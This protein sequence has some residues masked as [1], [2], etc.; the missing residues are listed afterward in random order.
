MTFPS[1]LFLLM[2]SL[3]GVTVGLSFLSLQKELFLTKKW[4]F[5]L[6]QSNQDDID[7]TLSSTAGLSLNALLR[8]SKSCDPDQMGGT[9]LAYIGDVV[10]E[11]FCRSR[12][13]WPLKRTSDLQNQ[14]VAVVR[15][16]SIDTAVYV[17]TNLFPISTRHN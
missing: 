10:F 16:T 12:Y 6:H 3:F 5:K 15:G 8:P 13:V 7:N 1:L 4:H 17:L 2:P 14:V 11:L 9:D